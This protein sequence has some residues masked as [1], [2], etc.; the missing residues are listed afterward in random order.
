MAIFDHRLPLG[1]LRV[2]YANPILFQPPGQS[3]IWCFAMRCPLIYRDSENSQLSAAYS[4]DGG[5]SWQPVELAVHW[6]SP[7]IVVAG[8]YT[9]READGRPRYLLP[10]AQNRSPPLLPSGRPWTQSACRTHRG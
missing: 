8:I 2:A 1:P 3:I 7:L 5:R 6:Q 9:V 10:T 4:V